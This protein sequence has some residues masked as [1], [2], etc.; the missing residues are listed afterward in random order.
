MTGLALAAALLLAGLDAPPPTPAPSATATTAAAPTPAPTPTP[1]VAAPRA[2][3]PSPS[4][5]AV[6]RVAIVVVGDDAAAA[7][8][9][10]RELE[11]A[12]V[13]PG[14]ALRTSSVLASKLVVARPPAPSGPSDQAKA[15]AAKLLEDAKNAYY[16]DASAQALDRLAKLEALQESSGGFPNIQ[17]V[18]MRL[19]RVAVFLAL[20]DEQQ[21]DDEALT[22]LSIEP[23]V[24]IDL[25]ELPPSVKDEVD[26]VRATRLR[27]IAVIVSGLPPV[28]EVK[29]DG[30]SVPSRF[31]AAVGHHKLSVYSPGRIEL[32]KEFDATADVSIFLPLPLAI[33]DEAAKALTAAVS[34]GEGAAV[35]PA[36]AAAAPAPDPLASLA[37]RLGVDWIAAVVTRSGA[38]PD[39][40]ALVVSAS[41]A[42]AWRGKAVPLGASA[43]R[44]LA[45]QI[46]P[47]LRAAIE[48]AK[49]SA[50]ASR[51]AELQ[52]IGWHYAPS[53]SLAVAA[54]YRSLEGGGQSVKELFAGT[55]PAL[56][57]EA[58]NGKLRLFGALSWVTYGPSK[59]DVTFDDGSSRSVDGGATLSARLGA[60]FRNALSRNGYADGP[61]IRYG[62]AL[63]VDEHSG[64]DVTTAAG[65]K[66]GLLPSWTRIAPEIGVGGRM[67]FG[68]L[69]LAAD[70]G[71]AP[72]GLWVD[73][74]AKV[75]GSS[76]TAST[77]I[78][79]RV[80]GTWGDAGRLQLEAA[81]AGSLSGAD[82]KGTAQIPTTP[83]FTAVKERENVQA[84]TL[85]VRKRF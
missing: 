49:R 18:E 58:V 41:G 68:T 7:G 81:W 35:P 6:P 31:R 57:I 21:A 63:L 1:A 4:P 42:T 83:A 82:H 2:P 45:D 22:A 62:L 19:W 30:R 14:I 70:V 32:T 71:V 39:A 51:V 37:S 43:T 72:V 36:P 67:P 10:Q 28:A 47:N 15:D 20:K 8:A 5:N 59:L 84:I 33:P 75:Y 24:K 38:T 44:A 80:S 55:G 53:A 27:V 26:K 46:G 69:A 48:K 3:S 12:L 52:E 64:H 77:A 34:D 73:S 56:A 13:T 60:G 74:P 79:W 17:R 11:H 40:R 85:G 65:G 66:L 29:V 23:D 50:E 25:K 78:A 16:D 54:R 9:L 76:S 61:S